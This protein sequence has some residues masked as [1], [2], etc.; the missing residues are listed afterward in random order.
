MFNGRQHHIA[1]DV[2]CLCFGGCSPTHGL[3]V[4]A[5][6]PKRSAYRRTIAASKFK[7]IGAPAPV[8]RIDGHSTIVTA[9]RAL[10]HCSTGQQQVMAAHD[11]IDPLEVDRWSF[12]CFATTTQNAPGSPVAVAGEVGYCLTQ[13]GD[14]LRIVSAAC[15]STITPMC[16]A[17]PSCLGCRARYAEDFADPL[18]R[19]SSGNKGERAIQFFARPYSTASFSISFSRV[20]LP[21]TPCKALSSWSAFASS[22]AGTTDSPAETADRAP[23]WCSLRHWNSWLGFTEWRRATVETEFPCY[24]ALAHHLQLVLQRPAPT[25]LGADYLRRTLILR[26]S[27]KH[28][29]MPTSYL[30]WVT[31]SEDSEGH[32][33]L[34]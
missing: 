14:Q 21:S 17:C 2:A 6:K 18:Q 32:S 28:S 11:Q 33:K 19:S 16:R 10:R 20:F 9:L 8:A 25:S 27:H 34:A 4:A 5:V 13:F 1:H 3:T 26:L 15:R 23:A 31:V 24:V 7:A 29:H 12:D 30:R 22:E